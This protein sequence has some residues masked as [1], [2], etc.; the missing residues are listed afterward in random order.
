MVGC[1]DYSQALDVGTFY[2]DT[3]AELQNLPT[4]DANGKENLFNMNSVKAGSQCICH[5]DGEVYFLTGQNKW[6]KL[7]V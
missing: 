5:E 6:E 1:I 7:D 3:I 4:L 2:S